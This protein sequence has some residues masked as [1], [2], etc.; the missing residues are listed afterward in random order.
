MST[1]IVAVALC[2]DIHHY[3]TC[4]TAGLL[5]P[6]TDL[7]PVWL[8]QGAEDEEEENG[9]RRRKKGGQKLFGHLHI[10]FRD[11]MY[12]GDE[13]SVYKTLFTNERGR[14]QAASV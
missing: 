14:R 3:P 4:R 7:F 11:W 5:R 12:A 1:I 9:S 2:Q 13:Q 8:T 6:L 10:V